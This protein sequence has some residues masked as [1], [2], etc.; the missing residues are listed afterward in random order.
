[1]IKFPKDTVIIWGSWLKIKA[2]QSEQTQANGRR[3]YSQGVMS[4][5]LWKVK[6]KLKVAV[7]DLV[8]LGKL[9]AKSIDLG[10]RGY[11]Y[12]WR[13]EARKIY[14]FSQQNPEHAEKLE[15]SAIFKECKWD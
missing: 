3:H 1:M 11:K 15:A 4:T 10:W 8:K 5:K 2:Y 14:L 6:N 7:A 12:V 9:K 13:W